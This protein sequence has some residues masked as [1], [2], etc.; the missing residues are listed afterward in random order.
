MTV[1]ASRP[2]EGAEPEPSP[3][4]VRT[5]EIDGLL[6]TDS[7]VALRSADAFFRTLITAM[8]DGAVSVDAN[9]TIVYANPRFAKLVGRPPEQVLGAKL[10]E[11]VAEVDRLQL[12]Q[13][14]LAARTQ[15]ARARV[16]LRQLDGTRVPVGVSA[17]AIGEGGKD[18]LCLVISDLSESERAAAELERAQERFR[19]A[20]E[21]APIGMALLSLDGTIERANDTLSRLLGRPTQMLIDT[22]IAALLDDTPAGRLPDHLRALT[23]GSRERVQR[24]V[25]YRDAAGQAVWVTESASLIRG[26]SHQPAHV[27][28]QIEDVRERRE[29]EYL[30]NHDPVTGLPNRRALE[31]EL[32]K[33]LARVARYGAEGALLVLD[34]DGFKRV[35]D[36]HGHATGDELLERVGQGLRERLRD[37]DL[38]ARLGGDEFAVLLP[39]TDAPG[40][41]RLADSMLE[42]LQNLT[43]IAGFPITA[44]VGIALVEPTAATFDEMLVRAD[45]AMYEAKQAGR[46]VARIYTEQPELATPRAPAGQL[47]AIEHA[48]AQGLLSLHAQPIFDLR[49]KAVRHVE[50]LVRMRDAAG[51]VVVAADF[52]PVAERYGIV[53]TI[54]R[55]V[56]GQAFNM[57]ERPGNTANLTVNVSAKSLDED[58]VGWIEQRL[59]EGGADPHRLTIE[60][61]E[62]AA[63]ASL[64]AGRRFAQWL[65]GLGLSLALDDFGAG[66]GSFAYLR[67]IPFDMLKI[68]G[69]FIR[70]CAIDQNA[71]AVLAGIAAIATALDKPTVAECVHDDATIEV[72][73]EVGIDMGQGFHLAPPEPLASLSTDE[74]S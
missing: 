62:T 53:G 38:V 67:R 54:D 46:G 40:A 48:V 71:R 33:H 5:G 1:Q 42:T 58:T 30:A 65:R 29:F 16:H 12:D 44:S 43:E 7:L 8:Q 20:F 56:L 37:S 63:I 70:D 41:L 25:R 74:A 13:L 72:L 73:R 21:Q 47:K 52:V 23:E 50:L 57:L 14:L 64:R 15:P 69:Q 24:E 9:A 27:L 35:N 34:L 49:T 22:P 26:E 55:W 19:G 11:L 68:D 10:H 31:L 39:K 45:L 32:T 28:V 59:H 60:L 36:T 3:E 18:E 61:T 4:G 6:S 17:V 51:D 66:F 2:P